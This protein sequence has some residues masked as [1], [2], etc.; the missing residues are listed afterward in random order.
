MEMIFHSDEDYYILKNG[1][2]VDNNGD[3]A[4]DDIDPF[5]ITDYTGDKCGDYSADGI[6]EELE[7]D[8][9][10]DLSPEDLWAWAESLEDDESEFNKVFREH[11]LEILRTDHL[12]F[13]NNKLAP[14]L[15]EKTIGKSDDVAKKKILTCGSPDSRGPSNTVRHGI[16]GGGINNSKHREYARRDNI[17]SY[18]CKEEEILFW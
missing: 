16:V 3:E 18:S 13:M 11:I 8:G 15:E 14:L 5:A 10:R 4:P 12:N 7:S 17:Y 1:I 2:W 6:M 9:L